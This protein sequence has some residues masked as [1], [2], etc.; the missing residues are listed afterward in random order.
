MVNQEDGTASPWVNCN[1]PQY[2]TG[3]TETVVVARNE[4]ETQGQQGQHVLRNEWKYDP[5]MHVTALTK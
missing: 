4:H 2:S 5:C 3:H 1:I